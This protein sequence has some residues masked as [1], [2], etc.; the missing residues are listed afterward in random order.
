MAKICSVDGCN[1][2]HH[3]KGY[4]SKHYIQI[5]EHGKIIET[6]FDEQKIIDKGDYSVIIIRDKN[7][8]EIAQTKIDNEDVEKVGKCKWF[9]DKHGY[10]R[11]GAKNNNVYLHRYIMNCPDELVVDHINRDKTDN[12]KSNLRICEQ[13]DN[14]CNR[15]TQSNNSLGIKNINWH[16]ENNNYRCVIKKDGKIYTKSSKDLEFLIQWRNEKLKELH[17]EFACI[18]KD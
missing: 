13:K 16:K 12:R 18:D 15:N 9:I 6:I 4:C 5:R 1:R 11:T 2:K 10:I 7:G 14:N 8:N 3:A 17:G